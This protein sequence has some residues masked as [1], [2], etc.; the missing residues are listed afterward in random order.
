M[1]K[2]KQNYGLFTTIAMI[3]GICIGSGIFFKSDNILTAT[4]GNVLLGVIVFILGATSILFG[5]LC[6]SELAART[7][8]PGGVI[9]YV[10]EF[11]NERFA[12]GMGWFQI[13]IYYPTI[14]AVVS[15]VV[16][17][18]I[19]ILFGWKDSLEL[20]ILIGFLFY[21]VVFIVN[22][23]SAKMGGRF[24]NFSTVSKLIPLAA[25]AVCGL[26]F[27]H[28][29]EG[30]HS[31]SPSTVNGVTWLSAIGP[32]AFSFDGWTI[33]TSIAHEVRDSK[34]NLPKALVIAPIIILII[35]VSYFIGVTSLLDPQQIMALGDEHIDVVAQKLF[36]GIGAKLLLIFVIISVMGT[37]NGIILGY[38]R[39]PYA[40]AL[41]GKGMFPFA[42][43]L[44]R[45]NKKWNM[46]LYSAIFCYILTCIWTVVHFITTKYKLLPNSDISEIAIVMSYIFYILLYYKVFAL[47]RKGKIESKFRGVV[48]PILATLGS[49]FILSGGLQSKWLFAYY[50]A[51]C[52]LVIAVSFVYYERYH[53][54]QTEPDT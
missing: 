19:F 13:F 29:A 25:I 31:V 30:F 53:R 15:W 34:K 46:P 26:I 35:Y 14:A 48:F 41:R 7:D 21:T 3:V 38:I 32:V 28:P 16:G 11:A 23:L 39:L 44:S 22:S 18:Y 27:G 45:L 42:D 52:L 49:L 51:F 40:M 47:Y 17:V 8:R 50:A 9:T 6:F 33:S 37:S 10:E 4:G 1:E 36:G 2:S 54:K 24:Q 20:E 5:G 43:K 12:C